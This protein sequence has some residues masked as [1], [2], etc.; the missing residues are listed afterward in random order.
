MLYC[1][2]PRILPSYSCNFS[3]H[4]ATTRLQSLRLT[5]LKRETPNGRTKTPGAPSC[6]GAHLLQ[7]V[8]VIA[9]TIVILPLRGHPELTV[10]DVQKM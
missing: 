7:Q 3:F 10:I 9:A 5:T 8:V 6:S 2:A 4:L 1:Y